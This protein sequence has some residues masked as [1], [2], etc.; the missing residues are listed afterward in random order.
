MPDIAISFLVD[1]Q[2]QVTLDIEAA[3]NV[4]P[5]APAPIVLKNALRLDFIRFKIKLFLQIKSGV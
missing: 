3:P 5:A 1:E 4:R 2:A